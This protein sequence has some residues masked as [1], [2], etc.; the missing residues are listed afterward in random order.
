[1]PD[2]HDPDFDED[3]EGAPQA[4]THGPSHHVDDTPTRRRMMSLLTVALGGVPLLGGLLVSLRAGLSPS[5]GERPEQIPLCPLKDVPESGI[6]QVTVTYRQRQGALVENVS[7]VVFVT[8]EPT[9]GE[10]I[11]MLGQCT[12]LACPVQPK[13]VTLEGGEVAPLTCPCHD[14]RFSATGEV[15]A[16]PPEK[17]L[18]RLKLAPL[19]EEPEG[20]LMLE[21]I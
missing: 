13:P 11:A 9:S 4:P 12:H 14:G 21:G 18:K 7:K 19:P 3:F 16:G 2:D 5:A 17:P 1:M 20:M 10:V 15:L 6:K 8:R